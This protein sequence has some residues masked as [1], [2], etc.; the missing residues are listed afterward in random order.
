MPARR[1]GRRLCG[2][3]KRQGEGL[4]TQ[5][6]GWG[7]PHPGTGKCRLHGGCVPNHLTAA[8][9]AQARDELAVL[10]APSVTD[11]LTELANITGEVVAW[12]NAMATKVNELTSLRYEAAGQ[13]G[14]GEQLRGE[15]ALWE[16]ALD[17]CEKFLSAMA[18]LNIDERLARVTEHQAEIVGAALAAALAD[19]GLP[20]EQQQEARVKMARHLRVV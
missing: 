13:G 4:C 5:P 14:G 7:T 3:K 15:V 20:L 9:E 16:R 1:A 11:P 17:R 18:R 10:G 2:S 8:V 12:K 19:M 6:A